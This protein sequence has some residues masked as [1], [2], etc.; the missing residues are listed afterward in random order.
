MKT[1]QLNLTYEEVSQLWCLWRSAWTPQDC[2]ITDEPSPLAI[3]LKQL[4]ERAKEDRK[5]NEA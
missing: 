4:W 3:K 2:A 5:N 1:Y